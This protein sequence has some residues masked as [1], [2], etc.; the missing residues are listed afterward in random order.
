MGLVSVVFYV[1]GNK[2]FLVF[3]VQLCVD[4]LA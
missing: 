2:D 1:I 3:F 4:F